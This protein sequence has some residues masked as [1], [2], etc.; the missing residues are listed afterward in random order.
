MWKAGEGSWGHQGG[1]LRR[2]PGP[3]EQGGE[4][5]AAGRGAVPSGL[6]KWAP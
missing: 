4:P 1:E 6:N 2:G 3:G 5:Q